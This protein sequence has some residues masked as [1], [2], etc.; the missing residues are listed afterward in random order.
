MNLFRMKGAWS[1]AIASVYNAVVAP[2]LREIYEEPIVTQYFI[3]FVA[4]QGTSAGEL[5]SIL[6][7]AGFQQV[8]VERMTDLPAVIGRGVKEG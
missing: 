7:L 8:A 4:E 5:E 2:A 3:R 1:P 6:G